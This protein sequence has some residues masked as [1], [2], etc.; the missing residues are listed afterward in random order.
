MNRLLAVS[1]P[2]A[3]NCPPSNVPGFRL[4]V[5]PGTICINDSWFRPALGRLS[6]SW[7]DTFVPMRVDVV[8]T[9]GAAPVTVTSS[10]TEATDKVRSTIS[11][12]PTA[13][14]SPLRSWLWKPGNSLRSV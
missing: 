2:F 7:F 1:R 3:L 14:T 10:L 13:T 4:G 8:S 5:S 12:W 9:T 6:I 11:S